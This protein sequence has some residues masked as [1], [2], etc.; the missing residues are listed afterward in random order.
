MAS[1][2][3]KS[4]PIYGTVD[5]DDEY[6]TNSNLLN[7]SSSSNLLA[8]G[9]QPYLG[10]PIGNGATVSSPTFVASTTLWKSVSAS[11]NHAGGIKSDGS[12]WMWGRNIFGEVGN[13]STSGVTTP[14]QIGSDTNWKDI[15]CGYYCNTALKTDGTLW[16]WGFN[17][18]GQLGLGD[19]TD[20]SS[21]CQ[22]GSANY[23]NK[24]WPL[25]YSNVNGML[26]SKNDGTLWGMGNNGN[27]AF[28]TGDTINRSSP[29]QIG[30]YNWKTIANQGSGFHGIL[31]DGTLWFNGYGSYGA[32]S[33]YGTTVPIQVDA[34]NDWDSIEPGMAI[35]KNGS[36]W[37]WG[38][39]YTGNTNFMTQ[40]GNTSDW[41]KIAYNQYNLSIGFKLDGSVWVWGPTNG[42][43][44]P[45]Q[46]AAGSNWKTAIVNG[47]NQYVLTY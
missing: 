30:N 36:A 44:T 10:L 3:T 21:P 14:I 6:I 18:V 9:S 7:F 26:V 11:G 37:Y 1:G 20:R 25:T 42:T 47:Y 31:T 8:W 38:G 34:A 46:Y 4:D 17:N 24:V 39:Y 43:S 41:R 2:F 16:S 35:K 29:V 27:G 15:A 33:F 12:L 13:N 23:W 45:V 22:V 28:A 5:L 19:T 40:L 32:Q